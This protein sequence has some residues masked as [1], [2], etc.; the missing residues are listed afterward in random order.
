LDK[1]S[2]HFICIKILGN[3]NEILKKVQELGSMRTILHNKTT[4]VLTIKVIKNRKDLENIMKEWEELQKAEFSPVLGVDPWHY[5]C[6]LESLNLKAEPYILCLYREGRLEGMLVG[7][8]QIVSMPIRLG[9]LTIMKPRF[10]VIHVFHGGVLGRK[11]IEDCSL[12]MKALRDCLNKGDADLAAFNHFH[13]D[14]V[15]YRVIRS[16]TPF[17]SL[18]YSP[19]IEGHWKMEMP[20]CLN[21]FI[22]S[23]SYKW[24]K[25][26]RQSIKKLEKS[27]RVQ[28]KTYSE[29][30]KLEEGILAAASV[31]SK[32]YQYSLD[33]GFLDN[34]QMRGYLLSAARRGWLRIYILYINN[35]AAAFEWGI[36]YE[37]TLFLRALGFDP[38]WKSWSVGTV[39]SLKVLEALC[40]EANVD[41]IDFGF[42]DAEYKKIF[43]NTR[44][45]TRGLT[46]CADRLYP[47]F[48]NAVRMAIVLM[49]M[50]AV[51]V[52]NKLGLERKFKRDWRD[53]LRHK[54]ATVARER[55]QREAQVS[56]DPDL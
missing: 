46:V 44:S 13:C 41:R 9:Y 20:K 12:L 21:E 26:L 17:L 22:G 37:R 54:V 48:L 35:E 39:L 6:E 45:D 18:G 56:D 27:H 32:T 40:E 2:A 3:Y 7:R 47:R 38:K 36:E 1:D 4:D 14:S 50:A 19:R 31:S 34:P 11:S 51:F 10:R 15:I 49:E 52:A 42:G 29:G 24:R 28:M 30:D 53:R 8:Y 5:I 33:A 16:E 23:K 25:T 43:C 55:T